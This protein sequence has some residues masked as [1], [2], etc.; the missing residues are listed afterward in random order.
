[1]L[2]EHGIRTMGVHA[3]LYFGRGK[4]L[5][6]GFD[7]WELVPGITFD[8]TTD[9]NVTSDKMTDIGIRVSRTRRIRRA[10]RSSR[11]STTPIRTTNT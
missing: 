4:Q 10:S 5:D 3:H 1:M 9:K 11:G 7:V 8:A 2:H 6:Q